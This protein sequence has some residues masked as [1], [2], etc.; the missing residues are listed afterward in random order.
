MHM[1]FISWSLITCILCSTLGEPLCHFFFFINFLEFPT[2]TSVLMIPRLTERFLRLHRRLSNDW[3]FNH[4][5]LTCEQETDCFISGFWFLPVSRILRTGYRA[6]LYCNTFIR[7]AKPRR[8]RSFRHF[9][10]RFPQCNNGIKTLW[11][12]Y[13]MRVSHSI[14]SVYALSIDIWTTSDRTGVFSNLQA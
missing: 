14:P 11:F 4:F 2:L 1:I 7:E 10:Q 9:G 13:L 8:C 6:S 3:Q 12:S 5:D